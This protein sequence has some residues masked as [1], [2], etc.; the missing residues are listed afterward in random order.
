MFL[1]LGRLMATD[2]I[3]NRLM[4]IRLEHIPREVEAALDKLLIDFE[5]AVFM[6][7]AD[8]VIIVGSRQGGKELGPVHVT[9]AG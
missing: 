6:L 7:Y 8:H 9:Q 1:T 4:E 2:K 5:V 3:H